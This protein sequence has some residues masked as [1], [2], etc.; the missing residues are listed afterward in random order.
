MSVYKKLLVLGVCAAVL[1]APMQAAAAN[2]GGAGLERMLSQSGSTTTEETKEECRTRIE[3]EIT[4]SYNSK[5]KQIDESSLSA[6]DKTAA[7]KKLDDA[8]A[9]ALKSLKTRDSK[10]WMENDGTSADEKMAGIVSEALKGSVNNGNNGSGNEGSDKPSGETYTIDAAKKAINDYAAVILQDTYSAD[11][12]REI[13]KYALEEIDNRK[14]K[15]TPAGLEEFVNKTKSRME[16]YDNSNAPADDKEPTLPAP[17]DYVQVGGNW[18]TPVATY[19][20][21]VNVVLPIV[22]MAK[23]DAMDVI[24]TPVLDTDPENWPFDIEQSSYTVKLD[25][26]AGENVNGDAMERRQEITWNFRTR[27]D[28]TSGYKKIAFNVQYTNS[29]GE[30]VNTTLNTYVKAVGAP[31]SGMG[32]TTS[33]PRLIVTGFDTDPEQ[34]RA[35]D[36]FTLTVHMKNTAKRTAVSNVEFTLKAATEGKDADAVYE[37]FLPVAGSSTIYVESIPAGGTTDLVIDMKAKADLA[38]KPYVLNIDMKYEDEKLKEFT[39]SSSVSIPVYQEARYE[40]SE[41]E[42]MP[43]SIDVGSESNVMFSIYN[44][45]KTTLYNVSVRFEGDSVSG[46]EAFVGNIQSGG[47][48]NVDTMLTGVA[49]T[50]DDGIIKAIISFE[51]NETNKTE[52]E[53]ELTLYVS[54]PVYDDMDM[55]D[56]DMSDDTKSGLPIWA[57]ILL[58]LVVIAAIVAAVIIVKKKK[59]ARAA[60]LLEDELA[61][62]IG[63]DAKENKGE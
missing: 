52:V 31:G 29:A 48:G 47:T 25:R 37:A 33:T 6:A 36:N 58:V 45:G 42:V 32:D 20:Q 24:V 57:K 15:W 60:S 51:D 59:K 16:K 14:D 2:V 26:L 46:G 35:G 54:E 41:P 53:K 9:S 23:E 38:Q 55:N 12:V 49:P 18:V 63:D 62:S 19:S 30:Q 56:Y 7:I 61:D 8:K 34:V 1:T 3:N 21:R 40:I 50:T 27:K 17:T 44:T 22:N 28:V 10:K 39:A 4:D 43:S 11:D 13:Q 5:V